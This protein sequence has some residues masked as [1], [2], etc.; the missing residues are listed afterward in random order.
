MSIVVALLRPIVRPRLVQKQPLSVFVTGA[1]FMQLLRIKTSQE[2]GLTLLPDKDEFLTCP[3][4][5]LTA[6]LVVQPAPIPDLS[7]Q[8]PELRVASV[9]EADPTVPLS[10]LLRGSPADGATSIRRASFPKHV[11]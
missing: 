6:A 11:A 5:I 7:A 4:F 10:G 3:L 2:R 1:F 8:L 9:V